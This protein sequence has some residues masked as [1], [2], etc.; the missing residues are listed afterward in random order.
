MRHAVREGLDEELQE[1]HLRARLD[2]AGARELLL[3]RAD[4]VGEPQDVEVADVLRP[5]ERD[6]GAGAPGAARPARPV[7]V[8]L[9]GL[10]KVVVDDVGQVRDV[11]PSRRHVGAHEEAEAPLA[12]RAHHALAVV[13][14]QVAV[15]PVGVEPAVL[16]RF[17]GALRLV[18]R[19]AE[20]DGALGVLHFEDAHELSDLVAS[21]RHVDVVRD[22]ERPHL[23]ARERDELRLLQVRVRE[24]LDVGGDGG[25]E[26]HPLPVLGQGLHDRVELPREA[27]GEHLVGLVE[28][29]DADLARVERPLPQVVEDPSRRS[30]HDLRARLERLDLARHRSPAVDGDD[31]RPPELPDLLHLARHLQR[32]LAGRTQDERLDALHRSAHEPVDDGQA[33]G[34]R[35][36][37]ARP[38]LHDQAAPF[39]RRLEDRE[40]HRRG[41]L[42][43]HRVDGAAHV[44]AEGECVERGFGRGGFRGRCGGLVH[45][46]G[47]CLSASLREGAR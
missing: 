35:L 4:L 44:G 6:G 47:E 37:G 12:G 17:G 42:V 39:G 5:D 25:A 46:W 27:H 3:D 20:D 33:E 43:A 40:L 15:Q 1:I 29:E 22:L 9:G 2:L 18:A 13:L 11:D 21:L 28:H 26:E 45:G 36:A 38:R 7:D 34:G 30:D 24:P 16:E 19:V 31:L 14:G 32:Q 23:V 10:G 8:L 41:V